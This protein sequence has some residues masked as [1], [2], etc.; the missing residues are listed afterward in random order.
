M[1]VDDFG[2]LETLVGLYDEPYADSS[3]IPTYRVCAAARE[4][5]TVALS[6][7]AGDENFAGYRRYRMFAA[8]EKYRAASFLRRS[9]ARSS[10]CWDRYYP[11]LDWAPRVFRGKTTFQALARDLCGRLPPRRLEL[12]EPMRRPA[13]FR[14]LQDPP[15]GYDSRAV[16][17]GTCRKADSRTP[18]P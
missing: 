7:D 17:A 11:K 13:V 4:R 1:E 2:L 10:A 6:G 12:R 3:A 9:A 14:P 15:G 5:V 16:F 18:W 8:E